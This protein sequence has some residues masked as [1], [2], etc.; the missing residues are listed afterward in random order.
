MSEQINRLLERAADTLNAAE[1]LFKHEY[2]LALANRAYYAVFYCISA[3]LLSENVFAK[4]HEGARSKFHELFVKTGCFDREISK[5]IARS[6]EA[7]QSADYNMD[8]DITE[9]QAREL[10]TDAHRFY[11]MTLDYF[12]KPASQTT[13]V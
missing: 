10:L 1:L 9:E 3:L 2:E 5:L 12:Q 11:Q 4:S 6:A 7:R 13:T 8:I